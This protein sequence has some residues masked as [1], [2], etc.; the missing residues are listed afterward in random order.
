MFA[1]QGPSPSYRPKA[2]AREAGL[3]EQLNEELRAHAV[4]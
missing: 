1:I 2:A 4:R 3:I